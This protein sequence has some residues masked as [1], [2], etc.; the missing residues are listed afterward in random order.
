[1]P[2]GKNQM[3]SQ[4]FSMDHHAG[5]RMGFLMVLPYPDASEIKLDQEQ[6]IWIGENRNEF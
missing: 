1:M 2:Q 3:S 6:N 4:T 5:F